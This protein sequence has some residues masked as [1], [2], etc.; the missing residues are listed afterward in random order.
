MPYPSPRNRARGGFVPTQVTDFMS[1]KISGTNGPFSYASMAGTT[2]LFSDFV[3]PGFKKLS[4][5]GQL[6]NKP[7]W[8]SSEQRIPSNGTV[9]FTRTRQDASFPQ[10][11]TWV[12]DYLSVALG[13]NL[14]DVSF[15]DESSLISQATIKCL[16]NVSSASSQILVS[17]A[18]RAKTVDMISNRARQLYNGYRHVRKGNFLAAAEVMGIR[19]KW[20]KKPRAIQT[21][22][23]WLEWR[24]GWL[25]LYLDARGA[26]EAWKREN[27]P[28]FTARGFASS[29][30]DTTSSYTINNLSNGGCQPWGMKVVNNA[31]T[32]VRA[33]QLY[34]IDDGF[35]TPS[36]FGLTDPVSVAWELIPF[37]FVVDW[38]V[39]VGTWLEAVKP[40]PG[41]VLLENGYTVEKIGLATES[42]DSVTNASNDYSHAGLLGISR[43]RYRR[44]KNRAVGFTVPFHPSLGTGINLKRA[45]DSIA[46]LVQFANKRK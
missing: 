38:F 7:K 40:T 13:P 43:G 14:P 35:V 37:S 45:L 41:V 25:P 20:I 5:Q 8:Q 23:N 39:D 21:S 32:N 33:Y 36:A 17:L 9:V 15:P 12:G 24:Y 31:I 2:D 18:E 46:L 6:I 16:S 10:V 42:V 26:V 19:N 1:G 22:G 34:T 28:R 11:H 3:T 4:A 30:N 27:H 29:R 44:S